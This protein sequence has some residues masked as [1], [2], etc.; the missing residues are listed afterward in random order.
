LTEDEL[1]EVDTIVVTAI[2]YLDELEEKFLEKVN[3]PI[4]SI[5]DIL[6]DI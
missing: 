2:T 1:E 6:Y 4:I 5:E 3:C